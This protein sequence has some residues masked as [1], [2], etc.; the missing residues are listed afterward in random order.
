MY[1]KSLAKQKKLKVQMD[2]LKTVSSSWNRSGSVLRNL[3]GKM[4]WRVVDYG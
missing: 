2:K 4:L 3:Y 1:E